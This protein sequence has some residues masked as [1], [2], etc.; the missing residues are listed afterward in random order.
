MNDTPRPRVALWLRLAAIFYDAIALGAVLFFA[1]GIVVAIAGEA[2]TPRNT[3]FNFYLVAVSYVY[4]A[5]CWVRGGQT[6]G[7]RT[8]KI[9]LLSDDDDGYITWRQSIVRFCGAIVS[10]LVCGLGF[11]AALVDAEG[12]TWH[13][14]WSRSRLVS[15]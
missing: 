15:V 4:F 3:P 9:L 13:D 6:L 12:R 8:W 10:W 1:A 7:M 5:F 14:R 11:L 2:V